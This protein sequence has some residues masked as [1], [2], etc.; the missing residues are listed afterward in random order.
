MMAGLLVVG[1]TISLFAPLAS[2]DMN[3]QKS[4]SFNYVINPGN[5]GP[6]LGKATMV[7]RYRI[8]TDQGNVMD[9]EYLW[10]QNFKMLQAASTT[11]IDPGRAGQDV[12]NI[13]KSYG[14]IVSQSH[15]LDSQPMNAISSLTG[16]APVNNPDEKKISDAALNT[17]IALTK[18]VISTMD[19]TLAFMARIENLAKTMAPV[20]EQSGG[21]RWVVTFDHL[22]G[23]LQAPASLSGHYITFETFTHG[24]TDQITTPGAPPLVINSKEALVNAGTKPAQFTY[25]SG[26]VV[27]GSALTYTAKQTFVFVRDGIPSG[28]DPTTE[29]Q[30]SFHLSQEKFE[31]TRSAEPTMS[32][33][34]DFEHV[35]DAWGEP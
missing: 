21:E 9:G 4:D 20:F 8:D 23:Y 1:L 19:P 3:G 33:G 15:N 30:Y 13:E 12:Y 18:M 5:A 28:H 16:G 24:N 25:E 31:R 26:V 6:N 27:H 14:R 34:D 10:E 17:V 11:I 2:A 29:T 35:L 7:T 22:T 32:L